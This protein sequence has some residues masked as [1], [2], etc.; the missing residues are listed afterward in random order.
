MVVV[1]VVVLL[2]SPPPSPLVL[3]LICLL[4]TVKHR[5]YLFTSRLILLQFLIHL[6]SILST[7]S[8]HFPLY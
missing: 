4:W 5:I 8:F 6:D 1:V 7:C 3:G 2:P